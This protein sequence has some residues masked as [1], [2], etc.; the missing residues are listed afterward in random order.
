MRKKGRSLAIVLLLGACLWNA[1]QAGRQPAPEGSSAPSRGIAIENYD[2]DFRPHTYYYER[3]PERIVALWQN[4]IETLL[5]LG[6]GD[7][8]IAAGG[9]FSTSF[10]HPEIVPAY[11]SIP[12]R[13]SRAMDVETLLMMEPDLIVGWLWDFS[14]RGSGIGR[15]EFWGARGTNVYM[16]SMNGA[17][18]KAEHTFDDEL[19]Y[20]RDL[21]RIIGRTDEAAVL[22]RQIERELHVPH[23]AADA[24]P[25]VLVIASV[26]RDLRIYTPRTLSG[27]LLGRLG[28]EVLGKEEERVGEEEFISYEQ[29]LMMDP[30]VIFV[31]SSAPE[32]TS[33]RDRLCRHPALRDLQAVRT[34]RIYCVPF[35][36]L[37]CPGARVADSIREL[38]TGLYGAKGTEPTRK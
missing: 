38:R 4:S 29:L 30:D 16:T 22:E 5:A 18:F 21:G 20:I 32:D 37:R 34:G 6:G 9:L 26:A 36:L 15:S 7:R 28:A 33:P 13:A 19:R 14:G 8:I 35:Y 11:E 10:L 3:P 23:G 1:A 24:P 27:D 17:E 12:I 2:S 25:R 31:Q